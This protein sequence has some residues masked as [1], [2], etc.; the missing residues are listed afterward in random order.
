MTP[1]P[2]RKC[3]HANVLITSKGY[4]YQHPHKQY[5]YKTGEECMKNT[6][7]GD[8][9]CGENP[10]V[11]FLNGLSMVTGNVANLYG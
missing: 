9:R 5:S 4:H 6:G 2:T 3:W 7:G 8:E 11:G 10:L 1:V